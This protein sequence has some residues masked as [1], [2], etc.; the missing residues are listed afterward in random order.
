MIELFTLPTCPI[1]DVVK[2][3]LAAKNIKYTE[4][5]FEELEL[6]VERAPV[7]KV[8]MRYLITPTDIN[9]WIKEA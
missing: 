4:H 9:E 1:C 7:I 3:K 6:N 5:P 2:K 8:G